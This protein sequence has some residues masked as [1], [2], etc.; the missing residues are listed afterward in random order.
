MA[1]VVGPVLG[2]GLLGVW[3]VQGI[4]RAA[5]AFMYVRMWRSR[6]WQHIEV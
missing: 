1:F 4:G 6:K 3:L 2:F 5:Q